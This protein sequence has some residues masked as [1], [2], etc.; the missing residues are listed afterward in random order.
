V[1]HALVVARQAEIDADRLGVADV[2]AAMS[3]STMAR[4]KFEEGAFAAAVLFLSML[5]EKVL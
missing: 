1:A 3:D 4:R 5:I 2:P